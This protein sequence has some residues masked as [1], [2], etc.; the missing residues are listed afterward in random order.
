[1]KYLLLAIVFLSAISG[2]AVAAVTF[3]FE[4]VITIISARDYDPTAS[5][6]I[7]RSGDLEGIL[8]FSLGAHFTGRVTYD[9]SVPDSDPDDELGLYDHTASGVHELIWNI[10][11]NTFRDDTNFLAAVL[12][13]DT[14]LFDARNSMLPSGWS[15]TGGGSVNPDLHITLNSTDDTWLTSDD[16]PTIVTL[17]DSQRRIQV[18][19]LRSSSAIEPLSITTPLG[20]ITDDL[21]S[22]EASSYLSSVYVRG[23]ITSIRQSQ[24]I[25]EPS[26]LIIWS[27]LATC[28][29]SL[30]RYRRPVGC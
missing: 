1:M 2:M 21:S 22:G 23:E 9:L 15:H 13:E 26:T 20:T 16:L 6:Y 11:T 5:V 24:V 30:G 14:L 8:D 12:L 4:G 7:D 28:A 10:G 19:W 18:N 3:E 29:L 25:P 17:P 27:F